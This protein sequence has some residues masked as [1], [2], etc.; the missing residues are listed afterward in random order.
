MYACIVYFHYA[1]VYYAVE[2]GQLLTSA[3]LN[4]MRIP[5]FRGGYIPVVSVLRKLRSDLGPVRF[6]LLCGTI[7]TLCLR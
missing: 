7:T 1:L 4:F 6:V 2:Y 3:R 5:G